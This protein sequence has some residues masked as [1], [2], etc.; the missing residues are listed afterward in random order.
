MTLAWRTVVRVG[1]LLV[2]CVVL[3]VS[4]F[5]DMRILG[6]CLPS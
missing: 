6:A 4:G 5:A 3:Q 1:I 2:L